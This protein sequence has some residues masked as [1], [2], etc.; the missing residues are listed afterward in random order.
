MINESVLVIRK[1]K[2]DFDEKYESMNVE[3][4]IPPPL[5]EEEKKITKKFKRRKT[6][7]KIDRSSLS[8]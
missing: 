1:A 3:L 8:S 7:K 2:D 4:I 6:Q 5:P